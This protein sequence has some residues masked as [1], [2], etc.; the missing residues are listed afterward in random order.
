M[1]L[2]LG[3][4]IERGEC[5]IFSK[6][7]KLASTVEVIELTREEWQALQREVPRDAR[8]EGTIMG[9]PLRVKFD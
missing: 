5:P 8:P 6:C 9:K 7:C 1:R 4:R 2:T 3:D